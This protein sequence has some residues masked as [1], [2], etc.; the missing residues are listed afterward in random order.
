DLYNDAEKALIHVKIGGTPDIRYCIKQ[1]LHSAEIYNSKRDV[2]EIYKI[3][4]VKKI[5]MLFVLDTKNII[6]EDGSIDF[7]ENGSIYFKIEVIEWLT[8]IRSMGF[9]A[10]ILVASNRLPKQSKKNAH[11]S[12]EKESALSH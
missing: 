6:K 4:E 7:M 2:L 8:K 5:V 1:S 3:K 10:E 12:P 9:F 11:N